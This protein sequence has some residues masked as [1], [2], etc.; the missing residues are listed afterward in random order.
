MNVTRNLVNKA[1]LGVLCLVQFPESGSR[2]WTIV[3]LPAH[4]SEDKPVNR[5]LLTLLG[6]SGS[7]LVVLAGSPAKAILP[8]GAMDSIKSDIPTVT[9]PI[10]QEEAPQVSTQA[11]TDRFKQL[12]ASVF[13]CTCANCLN[14]VKQMVQQ[15]SLSL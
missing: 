4:L 13:G 5:D 15:G 11:T 2:T 6:C 12:A 3:R 14:A 1:W 8:P 9:Q 7:L 10:A